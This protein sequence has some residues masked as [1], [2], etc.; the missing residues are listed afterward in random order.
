MKNSEICL[1]ILF[2]KINSE[3]VLSAIFNSNFSNTKEVSID[4][5]TFIRYCTILNNNITLG[6]AESIYNFCRTEFLDIKRPDG[7][8]INNQDIFNVLINYAKE[9]LIEENGEPVC[10]YNKLFSWNDISVFLGEDIF[11]TAFFA[12]KDLC[13]CNNRKSFN[14]SYTINHDNK[15]LRELL[16]NS[17]SELHSHL[18]GS[19]QN[20][21]L[22]WLSLMNGHYSYKKFVNLHN[23]Q[24]P[25]YIINQNNIQVSIFVSIIKAAAIRY[26]L[27]NFLKIQRDLFSS[28]KDKQFF[29]RLLTCTDEK[30][31]VIFSD[32]LCKKL[33]SLKY[34]YGY[35]FFGEVFDYAVPLNNTETEKTFIH[36]NLVLSGE[37]ELYYLILKNVYS[38]KLKNSIISN[39]FY[40]YLLIKIQLR[41]EFIQVNKTLGFDNFSYYEKRKT[42]FIEE[43]S[44][45]EKLK[46]ALAIN[47]FVEKNKNNYLETRITPKNTISELSKAIYKI[48]NNINRISLEN[49]NINRIS[50]ENNNIN[51]IS[52]EKRNK[53]YFYILHYIKTKDEI[54][55]SKKTIMWDLVPRNYTL[56]K[57]IYKKTLATSNAILSSKNCNERI[58]GIDA[59]NSE[60]NA[61]PEVFA[62]AFRYIRLISNTDFK[63][64]S[65]GK[66]HIGF[67]YHVGEDFMDIIDGLR[68]IDEVL[69]YM[70]FKSGD[71]LGHAL[72]L[73]KDAED[74][75]S[76]YDSYITLPSQLFL[77]NIAWLYN[78]AQIFQ[79]TEIFQVEYLLSSLFEKLFRNIYQDEEIPSLKTYY[80]SW[81]LRGDSPYCYSTL[82]SFT[83]PFFSKWQVCSL[84]L[85]IEAIEARKNPKARKLYYK[86]HFDGNVKEN[87][88]KNVTEKVPYE[89]INII[90]A[91]Q[92]KMII[93]IENKRI[94]IETNPTSNIKI[95]GFSRYKNHPIFIFNN[96]GLK[97]EYPNHFVNVSINTDDLGVFSTSLE[98]EYSLIA[99]AASEQHNSIDTNSPQ[100]VEQWIKHI[101]E[102]SK[103]QRFVNDYLTNKGNQNAK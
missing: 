17:L 50:L 4:K 16:S 77:D 38:G 99:M 67:T 36:N 76:T 12:F 85:N 90:K 31:M 93:E 33:H 56:R 63:T 72:V 64:T 7:T 24:F 6:T 57:D 46:T 78:K 39:L 100:Q 79:I 101:I 73:G 103:S 97:T 25:L 80:H 21:E 96:F 32:I 86:Y 87:G 65:H 42:L 66:P 53:S 37:R 30:E 69:Q 48:D 11:I 58:C 98:R 89:I 55:S 91:I 61:R 43:I 88:K 83:Y 102:L 40:A 51:C 47:T 70:N 34:M 45:Y 68:A 1:K 20:F 82:N 10:K 5:D 54:H 22:N 74:F 84:N 81:L 9:V 62:Q 94:A 14:W 60:L 28:D 95:G 3:E 41:K 26:I 75:Y 59:A 27:F 92:E 44:V 18:H 13:I 23:M 35:R 29:Y 49:N 8:I 2:S 52:L 15:T 19:S 71:R